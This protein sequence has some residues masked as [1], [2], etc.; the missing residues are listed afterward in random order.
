MT[1]DP[2]LDQAYLPI[3][4]GIDAIEK[5]I[6][7]QVRIEEISESR[8]FSSGKR[9]RAAAVLFSS[10]DLNGERGDVV[11]LAASV[12][13]IHAAS[14]VHDDV[15]DEARYRRNGETLSFRYGNT[16][17]VLTGDFLYNQAL[18]LI[19][20]I[21]RFDI[22]ETLLQSVSEM[23]MGELDEEIY[24]QKIRA[25]E[26]VYLKII[27]LK[28]ASL[29]RGAFVSGGLIK[30]EN[31][32]NI[33]ILRQSGKTFGMAYQI[34][35]DCE[36]LFSE[37]DGDVL[38]E[39]I[40]LPLIYLFKEKPSFFENYLEKKLDELRLGVV[41]TGG[42]E[43]ALSRAKEYTENGIKSIERYPESPIK[44]ALRGFF[45]YLNKK[46]E[47]VLS[48]ALKVTSEQRN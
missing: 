38:K 31:L 32:E 13:L 18:K 5:E 6:R 14:L 9:L 33:E 44:D 16:I 2:D 29:F 1:R 48:D 11:S 8:I 15:V 43:Y 21:N 24:P 22:M 30:N 26:E 40:T 19:H 10:G 23:I 36:D 34:I 37:K 45:E 28:T 46:R 42:Y 39:K 27:G 25:T 41:K 17:A 12:E 35:D 47:R 4:K 3:K 20:R 7:K